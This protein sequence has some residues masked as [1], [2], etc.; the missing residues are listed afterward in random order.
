MGE[1]V[2]TFTKSG[3][4]PFSLTKPVE[5]QVLCSAQAVSLAVCPEPSDLPL[6]FL[7]T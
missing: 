1:T 6:P 2:L 5:K 7:F 3:F 4:A